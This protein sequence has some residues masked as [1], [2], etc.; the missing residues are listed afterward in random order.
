MKGRSDYLFH[1]Y[2]AGMNFTD[3]EFIF[4]S[5][6]NPLVITKTFLGLYSEMK[7]LRDLE[8]FGSTEYFTS[9]GIIS[10]P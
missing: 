1:K 5:P 10:F 9:I 7:F 3:D 8:I 2:Q 4:S 6:E